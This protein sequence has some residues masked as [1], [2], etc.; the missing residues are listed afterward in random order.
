MGDIEMK[1][2]IFLV[3]RIAVAVALMAWLLARLDSA[4]LRQLDFSVISVCLVIAIIL[5]SCQVSFGAWRWK[6]LLDAQGIKIPLWRAISLSFQGN[7]FSLFMPGGALGGDVI[8]AT[9]V[10]FE[11]DEKKRME[12]ITTVALDRL[13]GM[14]ALFIIVLV[15]S[16]IGW[17]RIAKVDITIQAGI[18]SLLVGCFLMTVFVASLFFHDYLLRFRLFAAFIGKLDGMFNGKITRII[19]A[20]VLYRKQKIVLLKAF[21]ISLLLVHPFLLSTVF[22]LVW[23]ISGRR[24]DFFS[25]YLAIAL[26]NSAAVIPATPGGLGT[27]DKVVQT[28]LLAFG[29]NEQSATL[30]PLGFS[31]TLITVGG[32]GLLFFL[33]ESFMKR[34][35]A[36][37]KPEDEAGAVPSEK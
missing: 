28:I 12:G 34:S 31:V 7:A 13:I 30:A 11:S 15:I 1:K 8:K 2:K 37:S 22:V 10:A 18:V 36:R 26:G 27:R 32:I 23:G 21:L 33:L 20:I 24:P 25:T 6:L 35:F 5:M 17:P 14:S 16:A 29:V 19:S 9:I 4:K 3:L